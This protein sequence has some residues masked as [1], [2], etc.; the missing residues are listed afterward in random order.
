MPIVKPTV[1]F[2]ALL[3]AN[4]WLP[5]APPK[6][7]TCRGRTIINSFDTREQCETARQQLQRLALADAAMLEKDQD[8][9]Q[10][11]YCP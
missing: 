1:L 4:W 2:T 9:Y 7:D 8:K 10:C 11:V 5:G 3:A 6:A